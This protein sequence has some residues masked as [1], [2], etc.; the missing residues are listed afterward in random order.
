MVTSC[1]KESSDSIGVS[2]GGKGLIMEVFKH[3][4]GFLF[5]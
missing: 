1:S 4:N 5:K 3:W 2:E